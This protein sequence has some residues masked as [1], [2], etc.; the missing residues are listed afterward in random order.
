MVTCGAQSVTAGSGPNGPC[1]VANT[2]GQTFPYGSLQ[3][4][5]I[6][7]WAE[8]NLYICANG[9]VNICGV[10][11]GTL[12]LYRVTASDA[13]NGYYFGRTQVVK[14][15]ASLPDGS[16]DLNYADYYQD[17]TG[18]D[19]VIIENVAESYASGNM[20]QAEGTQY[21]WGI[22]AGKTD[23]GTL[24]RTDVSAPVGVGTYNFCTETYDQSKF[25]DFLGIQYLSFLWD[26]FY[27]SVTGKYRNDRALVSWY[28]FTVS[29]YAST[30]RNAKMLFFD[31]FN[32]DDEGSYPG[33]DTPGEAYASW[34]VNL[35]VTST[36]GSDDIPA[37]CKGNPCTITKTEVSVSGEVFVP[38]LNITPCTSSDPV[39]FDKYALTLGYGL[40][41]DS[42]TNAAETEPD[43]RQLYPSRR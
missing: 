3:T 41:L 22:V 18:S 23:D 12:C 25:C 6:L 11:N 7:I 20:L 34:N 5:D 21:V 40:K 36:S 10:S 43:R 16:T 29:G 39:Y 37:D 28:G 14:P 33:D 4:G 19:D 2:S 32:P 15:G 30:V 13:G 42:G 27:V 17:K 26:D 31:G 35:G 8:N 9:Q 1:G 24:I 38:K